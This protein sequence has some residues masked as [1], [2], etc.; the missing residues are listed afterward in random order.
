M[1]DLFEYGIDYSQVSYFSAAELTVLCLQITAD[2]CGLVCRQL[3]GLYELGVRNKA[4][5][6][7]SLV[8]HL[9]VKLVEVNLTGVLE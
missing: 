2:W 5:G 7:G 9:V 4:E 3:L 8:V 6:Q 1:I